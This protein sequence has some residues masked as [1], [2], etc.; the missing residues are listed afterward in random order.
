MKHGLVFL[1]EMGLV[2]GGVLAWA[3][4]EVV[5]LR[6]SQAKDSALAA[7]RARHPEGQHRPDQG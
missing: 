2:F 5:S 3:I 4:W 6:R 7:E 1:V